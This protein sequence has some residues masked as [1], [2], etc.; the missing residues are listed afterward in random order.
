MVDE[1][2]FWHLP[3]NNMQDMLVTVALERIE[4]ES[5]HQRSPSR[6]AEFLLSLGRDPSALERFQMDPEAEARAAGLTEAESTLLRSGNSVL[7][8]KA[9]LEELGEATP[10]SP[11]NI[12][13]DVSNV[14]W[15]S[16]EATSRLFSLARDA[17]RRNRQMVD[18]FTRVVLDLAE[19]PALLSRYQA[20][21]DRFLEER[22]L[23]PAERAVLQSGDAALVRDA[24]VADLSRNVGGA[25]VQSD[26]I[27]VVVYT[28]TRETSAEA[29]RLQI[30]RL[31][32]LTRTRR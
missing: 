25:T 8:R 6:F 2:A 5:P 3:L 24:I 17:S 19:N 14:F 27:T 7:I 26:G 23:S 12:I 29:S 1:R 20:S 4:M 30:G 22:G 13:V 16:R 9:V 28:W 21:P 31:T 18:R 10:D 15:G 11:H 32:S